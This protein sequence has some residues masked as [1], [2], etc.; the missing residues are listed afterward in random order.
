[1]ITL[2]LTPTPNPSPLTFHPNPN[3]NQA[4]RGA[5]RRRLG[6]PQRRPRAQGA[7]TPPT[8]P[9]PPP[10]S[11]PRPSG[12]PTLHPTRRLGPRALLGPC[13]P[14]CCLA[15]RAPREGAVGMS[16]REATGPSRARRR[17]LPVVCLLYPPLRLKTDRECS[18]CTATGTLHARMCMSPA[19]RFTL[20]GQLSFHRGPTNGDLSSFLPLV[21]PYIL[22]GYHPTR[23]ACTMV[24]E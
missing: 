5:R 8:P 16:S 15:S 2:T 24:A 20:T 12:A 23:H 17:R 13:V 22:A 10:P 4:W 19:A 18:H 21:R 7:L 1:M 11:C 9:P 6:T 3:P 14:S